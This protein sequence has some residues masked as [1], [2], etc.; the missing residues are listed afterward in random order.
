MG[1]FVKYLL[2]DLDCFVRGRR[3]DSPK[4]IS[5]VQSGVFFLCD[6]DFHCIITQ[7]PHFLGIYPSSR[8]TF[9]NIRKIGTKNTHIL[10][11]YFWITQSVFQCGNPTNNIKRSS[12][13]GSGSP[14]KAIC[15]S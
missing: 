14:L 15:Y 4:R 7:R 8:G 10:N 6:V 12:V 2:R 13:V 1:L 11:N 9:I 5:L 3:L